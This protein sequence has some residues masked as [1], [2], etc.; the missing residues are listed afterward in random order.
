MLILN[1]FINTFHDVYSPRIIVLARVG[2]SI[3]INICAVSVV[4]FSNA[5]IQFIICYTAPKRRFL[6]I[7]IYYG[8]WHES[9]FKP[10]VRKALI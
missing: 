8:K 4:Y 3:D 1:Q 9:K 7:I 6:K 2:K 10:N 5:R